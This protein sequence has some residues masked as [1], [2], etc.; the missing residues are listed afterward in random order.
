MEDRPWPE[1]KNGKP[2]TKTQLARLLSRF[3]IKPK[4]VRIG[5]ETPR[6]YERKQFDDAFSRYL[7]FQ[8][9]TPQQPTPDVDLSGFSKCNTQ[10]DVAL[11]NDGNSQKTNECCSVADQNPGKDE[12]S[13]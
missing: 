8:S 5:N 1:W 4:G 9:A 2:L 3:G 7:A 10:N 13:I 11:Q 6:G 12:E